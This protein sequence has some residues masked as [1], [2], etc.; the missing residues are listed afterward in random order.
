MSGYRAAPDV[1]VEVSQQG[2][3]LKLAAK[4]DFGSEIECVGVA[5]PGQA[6]TATVTGRSRA[7]GRLA[8]LVAWA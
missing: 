7:G 4:C 8:I 5:K 3:A 6:A 2:R 1:V